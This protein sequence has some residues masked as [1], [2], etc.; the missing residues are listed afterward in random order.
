LVRGQWR[1][2]KVGCGHLGIV[3]YIARNPHFKNHFPNGKR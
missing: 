1:R 2:R 3:W